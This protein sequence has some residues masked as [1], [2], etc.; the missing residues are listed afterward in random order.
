MGL[1]CTIHRPSPLSRPNLYL[2]EFELQEDPFHPPFTDSPEPPTEDERSGLA[3]EPY[4]PSPEDVM[5][6]TTSSAKPLR[7]LAS[8]RKGTGGRR[9]NMNVFQMLNQ[10][11]DQLVKVT[12]LQACLKMSVSV[13]KDLTGYDRVMIYQFDEKWN[14]QV[15]AELVDWSRTRDLYRGLHFPATD[16]P[17]QAR[18]LYKI[19]RVRLLYDR[20]QP[21]ARMVCK[22]RDELATPLDMSYTTLRAMSPI[23]IKYLANMRVR[24]SG[25]I[26]ITAFGTLWGL[27]SCHTYGRYG[28]RV[29]SPIRQLCR[30]LGESISRNI[31]RLTYAE[32]LR[33]RRLVQSVPTDKNPKGY[34]I[35]NARD[36]LELFDAEFGI[37]SVGE[38]SKLIGSIDNT[39]E[40]LAV[41]EYIRR[42]GFETIQVSQDVTRDYPDLNYPGGL[43]TVAGLLSVPLSN[44]GQDFIALFRRGQTRHVHWA[45]NPYDKLLKENAQSRNDLEPRTSFKL[46][47]EAIVGKSKAWT[48]DQ[49][50]TA[51]VL[52]L[53]YGKF[54]QVWRQKEIAMR[55]NQLTNL[56]LSNASHEVRTPLNAI[57]NYL[58]MALEGPLD[59]DT[60]DALSKSYSASKSLVHVINDLL[61]LTRTEQG[62]AL[63]LEEP[64]DITSVV[65]EATAIHRAEAQRK[66]LEFSVFCTS[67]NLRTSV[68]GDRARTKQVLSNLVLNALQHTNSGSV[69]LHWGES[70]E[71]DDLALR[72]GDNY[73]IIYKFV[74]TDT[75]S[76]IEPSKLDAIFREFEEV[77]SAED[78]ST[79]VPQNALGLGLAVVARIVRNMRGQL[80]ADSQEKQGSRF[81][82]ALPFRI[83]SSPRITP[84]NSATD[85]LRSPKVQ[86]S[87]LHRTSSAGS[88]GSRNSAT[89]GGSKKSDIDSLVEAMTSPLDSKAPTSPKM[90]SMRRHS[91]SLSIKAPSRRQQ[92]DNSDMGSNNSI[93]SQRSVKS[94]EDASHESPSL[95]NT[96][97]ARHS[98]NA[99]LNSLSSKSDR[100]FEAGERP[101]RSPPL[102][103]LVV[104]DD[105]INRAIINKKLTKEGH[106]VEMTVHGADAVR[107]IEQ[108]RN[109]N[110]ILMDLQMPICDGPTATRMIRKFEEENQPA[111]NETSVAS[112]IPIIAVSASL[113]EKQR[114]EMKG[115]G[116]DGWLLK[117]IAFDRM[118]AVLMGITDAD[119]RQKEQY[120]PGKFER[121][122]WF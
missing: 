103:V 6:S 69:T 110:V 121:G 24:A 61:D 55:S 104:E 65:E 71:P 91:S 82:V 34:I 37:L 16:I 3:G 70:T 92:S 117:P 20:D 21:T 108:D 101:E 77:T 88:A 5:E 49:L 10:I 89:S 85:I 38:E 76:G 118:A 62:E 9:R 100:S 8:A 30:I 112:R 33:S 35:A 97:I 28:M 99:S 109:F 25:S 17:A 102:R 63:L 46:W 45:G 40:A 41:V 93:R 51:S 31:E 29:P 18:E 68:I 106:T 36:L 60:R 50:E 47:S 87:K 80:R 11:T 119:A 22:S 98:D 57:V 58:E 66:G 26:S 59:T 13:I 115:H 120:V 90:P 75:G 72:E 39:S 86:G 79:D 48:D 56:L 81:S 43:K 96:P 14:G 54:I 116:M 122:G 12:D 15:V 107:K 78:G 73:C 2:V 105:P 32:R 19:N 67:P 111:E 64:V 52:C 23:H 114:S 27:I 83:P 7:S 84:T 53:V 42:E 113:L 94:A 4:V 1:L 95:T 74:I 44:T